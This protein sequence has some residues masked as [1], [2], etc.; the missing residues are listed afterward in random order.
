MSTAQLRRAHASL[1]ISTCRMLDQVCADGLR[2]F[3]SAGGDLDSFTS[4][5]TL[6]SKAVC[7]LRPP[8]RICVRRCRQPTE[9]HK[10]L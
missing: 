10:H 4:N 2:D 8:G 6:Y 3:L 9:E 1:D 7:D 5:V